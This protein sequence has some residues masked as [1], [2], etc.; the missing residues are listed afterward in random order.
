MKEKSKLRLETSTAGIRAGCLLIS[1]Q[2]YLC[3]SSNI[4]N[5]IPQSL[6]ALPVGEGPDGYLLPVALN[7]AFWLNVLLL[8]KKPIFFNSLKIVAISPIDQQVMIAKLEPP[9]NFSSPGI[10]LSNR[11]YKPFCRKNVIRFTLHLD[12]FSI[13][14]SLTDYQYYCEFTG[15]PPPSPL[16]P[17]AGFGGWLL[18]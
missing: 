12:N 3:P 18:P 7:E 16:D 13:R 6:G 14:L 15:N 8:S 10:L 4:I 9:R 17:N 2:R 1:F 5:A 11:R